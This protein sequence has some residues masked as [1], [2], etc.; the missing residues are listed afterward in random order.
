VEEERGLLKL[1]T[2]NPC[3][4]RTKK[5]KL[6][7]VLKYSIRDGGDEDNN[8]ELLSL[9]LLL[10]LSLLFNERVPHKRGPIIN[11]CSNTLETH[12]LLNATLFYIQ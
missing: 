4:S 1:A 6:T 9:L 2:I 7:D 11:T 10:L 8:N 3:A 12:S 5:Y